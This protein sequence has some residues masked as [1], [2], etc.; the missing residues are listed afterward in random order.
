MA[1]L[2]VVQVE[3]LLHRSN[4][5][6]PCGLDVMVMLISPRPVL[7]PSPMTAVVS[8]RGVTK[9]IKGRVLF[10]FFPYLMEFPCSVGCISIP[11]F[12]WIHLCRGCVRS[13]ER[14]EHY[15]IQRQN[16]ALVYSH[17]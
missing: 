1:W 8:F 14:T 16:G 10:C 17:I 9:G 3:S 13:T 12:V 6:A 15:K 5:A 7:L 11:S 2:A 4:I